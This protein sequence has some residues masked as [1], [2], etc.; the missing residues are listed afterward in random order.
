MSIISLRYDLSDIAQNDFVQAGGHGQPYL[1]AHFKLHIKL[2]T[3]IE[4]WMTF[5][6]QTMGSVEVEYE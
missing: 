4:F 2:E 1:C 5:G 6:G 3:M